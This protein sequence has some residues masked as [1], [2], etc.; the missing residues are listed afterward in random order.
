MQ[1]LLCGTGRGL[2]PPGTSLPINLDLSQTYWDTRASGNS[3]DGYFNFNATYTDLPGVA[4]VAA[5]LSDVR[6]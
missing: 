2:F 6:K 1:D 4:A 5:R 3:M